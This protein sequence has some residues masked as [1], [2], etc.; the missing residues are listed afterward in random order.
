MNFGTEQERFWAG[1]FGDEYVDRN[2]GLGWVA[3]NTALFARALRGTSGIGSVVEF[4]ANIGLNLLALRNLFP[5]LPLSAVE[6]NE[7]AA[8]KL[9]SALPGVEVFQESLLE[10][11]PEKKWD[12]VLTKG[13]LIHINPE[14]LPRV[15][16]LLYGAASKYILLS[17]YYNPTPVAVSYRGHENRLFKRDFAGE[18]M[19]RYRDVRLLDYGFVYHRDPNFRQD[20]M[21]WFLLGKVEALNR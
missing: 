16:E 21:N 4:G 10:F 20:D 17:E 8:G 12:L 6:I 14:Q 9:K 7:K 3:S 15:Y 19:D 11:R 13:V 2:E 5:S 1:T 18:L